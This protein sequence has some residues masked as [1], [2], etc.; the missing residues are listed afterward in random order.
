M[1]SVSIVMTY[2]NRPAQLLN[3]LKSIKY[4]N[5]V[6]TSDLQIIVVD[7]A[8]DSNLSAKQV[9]KEAK[10]P[11]FLIYIKPENKHWVNPGSPYNIGF[12]SVVSDIVIIQN[13]ECAHIGPVVDIVRE[14][15]TDKNYLT[16]AAYASTKECFEK[17]CISDIKDWSKIYAMNSKMWY[18]HPEH[19]STNYHFTSALTQYN[20]N[21]IGGFDERFANGYCFEDNAFVNA[22]K[23]LK[24]QIQTPPVEKAFVVHQWHSK[25]PALRGGCPLWEKN[26]ILYNQIL[27][28][29]ISWD[30]RK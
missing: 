28:G 18:H 8:S 6:N 1:R 19:N 16:F 21:R 23:K 25:N 12:K 10:V 17:M 9:I 27:H 11:G 26:R 2:Y 22:I 24:L 4:Y 14:Q 15:V 30:W 7:D 3:T 20:L 13:S 5:N 29:E